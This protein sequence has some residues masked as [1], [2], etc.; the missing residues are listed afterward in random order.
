MVSQNKMNDTVAI[1]I[2]TYNRIDFLERA[3]NSVYNC[4]FDEI[5]V[6]N[7]NSNVDY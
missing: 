4:E 6:I 2:P 3:I 7:D 5:I 1:I